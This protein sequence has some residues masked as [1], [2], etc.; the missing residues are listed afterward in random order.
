MKSIL[1]VFSVFSFLAFSSYAREY[2]V[3][4]NGDDS[5]E[6]MV[7]SPLKTISKAAGLAMPGD[8]VIVHEGVYREY[9]DPQRG[10]SSDDKRIVYKA[11]DNENVVI[12]G[13]EVIKNWKRFQGDVWKVTIPNSFFGKFNPYKEI[14]HG[15]WFNDHGRSHHLGQVYLNEKSFYESN[16]LQGVVDPV[17]AGLPDSVYTWYCETDKENTYIYANFKGKKPNKE[18]VEI[19]VRQSCFY[20]SK[21]GM[22][23]I[24]VS[25]FKMSQAATPWAP[26]TAEQIGLLGTHWSKGWIIENNI[27]SESRCVGITL[28]KDRKTGQNVWSKNRCKDGATHYNEVIFRALDAGWSKETIGSHIVRNNEIFNCEQAGMVGSLGAVFSQIYGNHVHDIW[29]KRQFSGAEIAGIKIHAPIDCIIRNNHIHNAGRGIWLDWMTQG[30]RVT[31][32]LFY[33]NSQDDIFIEVNHGPFLI[34]NNVMLS[35]LSIRTWSEGGFYVHNLIAG[36]VEVQEIRGR[37]TPYHFAHT[38]KVAGLRNTYSGVNKFINNIFMGPA[39]GT[40]EAKKGVSKR[41]KYGIA[42]FENTAFSVI[43]TGNVYLGA[44]EPYKLEANSLEIPDFNAD[45]E[46]KKAAGKTDL[47]FKMPDEIKDFVCPL[48]TTGVLGNTLISG[49]R[50]ENAD[51]SPVNVD[52]DYF[53]KKRNA[54]NNLPGP[55]IG[56]KPGLNEF[57]FTK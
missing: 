27:I 31:A 20:P 45:P 11:G 56:I 55:F 47:K 3:S 34:D 9:V 46:V 24:T 17:S 51:G 15:D 48:V 39:K 13:S 49:L 4:V 57:V 30:T 21:T 7:S 38:T 28:G 2:H 5:N 22:N 33:D 52:V 6:G 44:A 10:G 50:I 14:I 43:A 23:Y 35:N 16:T 8:V 32:N 37:F 53:G 12:K 41:R 54:E 42:A 36:M 26:P 29:T 40:E 1:F 18:S 25:G 19:N